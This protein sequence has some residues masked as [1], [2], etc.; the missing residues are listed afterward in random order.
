MPTRIQNAKKLERNYLNTRGLGSGF[1]FGVDPRACS[2]YNYPHHTYDFIGDT[3]P[4]QAVDVL[5]GSGKGI[6]RA[7]EPFNH[8]WAHGLLDTS[9]D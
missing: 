5:W 6:G 2:I 1:R 8:D 9:F 7:K 4:E 3:T